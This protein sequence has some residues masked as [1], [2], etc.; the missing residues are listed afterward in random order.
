MAMKDE[1][2]SSTFLI[3]LAPHSREQMR[4]YVQGDW[5]ATIIV[6][7]LLKF[8]LGSAWKAR[9]SVGTQQKG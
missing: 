6:A 3:G 9:S 5:A 4:A 1:E 8:Y 2:A 7:E